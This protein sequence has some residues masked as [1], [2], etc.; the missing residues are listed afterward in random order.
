MKKI[1]CLID[2]LGFGGAERQLIG[3]A[4]LLKQKGYDVEMATYHDFDF[5]TDALVKNGIKLNRISQKSNPFTKLLAV[6]RLVNQQKYDVVIAYKSGVTMLACL[7]KI[8]GG[9]FKLIVSERNT[10]QALSRKERLKFWLYR[11][12]D[13]IVPN[14]HTQEAFIKRHYPSLSN[15]IFTITNFTDTD[16]FCAT[17]KESNSIFVILTTARIARQKN[18]LAYLEAV[19][20]VKDKKLNARFR[21][22]G[23][24]Q[25]GEEE[26]GRKCKECITTLGIAD[27]FEFHPA[28]SDILSEYQL[29]DIFCLPSLYEGYPN[30]ICEAM[31]CGKPVVCSRVCDNPY[32]VEEGENGLL[33]DPLSVEDMAEKIAVMIRMKSEDRMAW[34]KCN[35]ERAI[36][37]FSTET[38]V[39]KY[40]KLIDRNDRNK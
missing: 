26:Y 34:G 12:A 6:K 8:L 24:V 29:C 31:S 37:K 9:T 22:L 5:D 35:R 28:K 21:W 14:S 16:H 4:L 7:L 36:E 10:T 33:F 2:R 30:V 13:Y 23:N 40:V 11:Y 25:T 32:I 39:K 15:K 18:V 20:L 17:D 3:L 38:F 19:R 1:L 27:V